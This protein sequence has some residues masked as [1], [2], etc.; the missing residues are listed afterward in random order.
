VTGAH[1]ACSSIAIDRGGHL[2]HQLFEADPV[3]LRRLKQRVEHPDRATDTMHLEVD[4]HP[5]GRRPA[6]HD[7]GHGQVDEAFGLHGH[8]PAFTLAALSAP[9]VAPAQRTLEYTSHGA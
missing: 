2:C 3:L 9:F 8:L 4:E 6:V 5:D 1:R 7:L